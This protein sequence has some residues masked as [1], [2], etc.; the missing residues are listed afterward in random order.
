MVYVY[1][2]I[3][4]DAEWQSTRAS[5]V[6]Y[7][8][9]AMGIYTFEVQAVDRD[10]NYSAS[11]SVEVEVTADSRIQARAGRQSSRQ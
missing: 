3:G 1:R 11:V 4:V 9:L 7:R 5:T 6:T 10:L 2:L 8:D